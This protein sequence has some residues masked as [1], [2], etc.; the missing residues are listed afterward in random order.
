MTPLITVDQLSMLFDGK[1]ALSNVSFEIAE[2]EIMG[3]IGRSGAG[4]TVLMHLMRGVDQPP[5]GGKI[6]YHVA[7]CDRCENIDSRAWPGSP[8]RP[9]GAH[10]PPWTWISGKRGTRR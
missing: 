8:A 6:I 1:K 2:G 3:I 10:S 7:V 9:A 4:K 5:T